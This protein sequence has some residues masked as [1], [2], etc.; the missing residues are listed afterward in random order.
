MCAASCAVDV[1]ERVARCVIKLAQKVG[2]PITLHNI[3]LGQLVPWHAIG[4]KKAGSTMLGA[5]AARPG[6]GERHEARA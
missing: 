4:H 2:P 1:P 5:Y 6:E 3:K